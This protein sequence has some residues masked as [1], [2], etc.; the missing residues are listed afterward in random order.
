LATDGIGNVGATD[1]NVLE[2]AVIQGQ[3]FA[4]GAAAPAPVF[5]AKENAAQ[6]Q[7]ENGTAWR[8]DL[9]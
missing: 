7:F 4:L 5:N 6:D 3:Q 2:Q 1:P 9:I 8:Y